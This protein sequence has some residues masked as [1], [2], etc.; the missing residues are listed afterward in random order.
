MNDSYVPFLPAWVIPL[1]LV[2][3]IWELFWKAASMWHAARKKDTVWF[4]ILLIFN[5]VGIL[6]LIYLFGFE[7]VKA[8]KLFK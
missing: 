7:K 4:F 8:A 6:D 5:T 2:L 1:L 3:V